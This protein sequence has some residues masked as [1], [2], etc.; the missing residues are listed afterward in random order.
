MPSTFVA[1]KIT[2]ALISMARSAA[3]VSVLKKGLPVPAPKTTTRPFSRCRIARR[4]ACHAAGARGDA[5]KNVAAADDDRRLDAHGLDVG[6]IVGNL[7]R[8][9][10]VDAVVRLAHQ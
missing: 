3:A 10:R 4:R 1:L 8:H 9:N 6:D 7:R 5:E 2:S